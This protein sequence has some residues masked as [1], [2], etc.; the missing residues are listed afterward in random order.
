MHN[1]PEE[2]A[3]GYIHFP[4]L[5][6]TSPDGRYSLRTIHWNDREVIRQWRNAQIHVLRQV[7]PLSKEDQDSYFS[8]VI[9][10]ELRSNQ[11]R[12]ILFTFEED[13]QVVGY[14]GLVHIVWED[15]R[16]EVSFLTSPNRLHAHTFANDW[17]NYLSLLHELA[18]R[19]GFHKLTTETYG[20]R[21]DVI[22]ILEEF[23]FQREGELRE[24]HVISSEYVT[25]YA[26]GYIL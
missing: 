10:H 6:I 8:N 18:R 7:N 22:S 26:H 16:A 19:I 23:G 20:T 11:P 14:G 9:L 2:W 3:K 12:Q 17:Q 5:E 13:D 24:H 25:S 15:K 21:P 4:G 1:I